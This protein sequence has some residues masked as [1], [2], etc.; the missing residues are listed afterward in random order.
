MDFIDQLPPL[1]KFDATLVIVDRLTKMSLFIPT[2]TTVTSQGLAKLYLQHVF[3]KHGVPSDI[4]SNRG[5]KFTLNFW[6]DLM[7]TLGIKQNLLT[8]YHPET[9]GQTERVNQVVKTYLRLYINYDQDDWA[10]YLPLAEFAYNNATHLLTTKSPFYLN[11][12]FHPTLDIQVTSTMKRNLGVT[13]QHIH[14]LH[15]HAKEKIKKA[16]QKNERNANARR[17]NPPVYKISD[18]VFLAT[19]NI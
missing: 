3:S 8:A 11:K 2:T 9:D 13:I 17:L 18:K 10:D 6:K 12:G 7:S 1:G 14:K 4:V 19:T 16:L 15:R 5:N